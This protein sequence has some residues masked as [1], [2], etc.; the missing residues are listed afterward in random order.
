[1]MIIPDLDA[2]VSG[3]ADNVVRDGNAGVLTLTLTI[4]SALISRKGAY[5]YLPM[6]SASW[7]GR[8]RLLATS[9]LSGA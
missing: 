7:L 2:H 9:A 5:S 8:R 4:L 1:M 6:Q 3:F